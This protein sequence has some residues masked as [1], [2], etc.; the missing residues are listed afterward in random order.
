[1]RGDPVLYVVWFGR[2]EG[3]HFRPFS[4][5]VGAGIFSR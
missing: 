1:M 3:C 2:E 5:D 4:A